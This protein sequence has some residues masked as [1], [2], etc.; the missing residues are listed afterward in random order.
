MPTGVI[1]WVHALGSDQP[2]Q[3]IFTNRHNQPIGDEDPDIAGVAGDNDTNADDVDGAEGNPDDI[4]LPG[5]DTGIDDSDDANQAPPDFP[6]PEININDPNIVQPA[7]QQLIE[8][9]PPNAEVPVFDEPV[10]P[11]VELSN[12]PRRF[13]RIRRQEQRY[14]PTIQGSRYSYAATQIAKGVLYPDSHMFVQDDFY[15]YDIDVVA[16]VMN[17][18]SLKAAL[19]M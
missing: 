6:K 18:L 17:Q 19:K 9:Q 11:P 15:Q 12:G 13:T 1:E 8:Q 4:E 2:E 14:V 5:V 7:D 16:Y 10:Q 3:L